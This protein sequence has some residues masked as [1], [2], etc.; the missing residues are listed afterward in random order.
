MMLEMTDP[1][2]VSIV[3]DTRHAAVGGIDRVQCLR[4]AIRASRRFT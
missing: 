4:D 1:G 3:L 2:L